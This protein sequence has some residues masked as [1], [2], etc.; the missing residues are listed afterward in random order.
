MKGALQLKFVKKWWY[1]HL[2]SLVGLNDN[3]IWHA[4]AADEEAG[5][6]RRI[7]RSAD[8]KRVRVIIAADPRDADTSGLT[9]PSQ[10]FKPK[11]SLRIAF[12]SRVS[13]MKNLDGAIRFLRNLDGNVEFHIFGPT[14]G[15]GLLEG[16]PT[17]D[18][19]LTRPRPSVLRGGVDARSRN[20]DAEPVS[21]VLVA[22]AG[23]E[24][25][26][27]DTRGAPCGTAG[28]VATG[29]RGGDFPKRA[30][31]SI[32]RSNGTRSFDGPCR[33]SS[34][35][36]NR[37]I[38]SGR[39]ELKPTACRGQRTRRSSKRIVNCFM[40]RWARQAGWREPL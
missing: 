21:C 1:R 12:L 15:R 22:D 36:T 34:T 2:S 3:V 28:C 31:D 20:Q 30:L 35:W 4:S 9:S 26:P 11:G 39:P 38:A 8:V 6:R 32:S 10:R 7:G 24:L 14:G 13:R 40:P 18:R 5:I 23:R 27:R 17:R 19:C 29:R 25:W 33:A 37:R 16:M